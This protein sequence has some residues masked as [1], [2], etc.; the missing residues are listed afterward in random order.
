MASH[1]PVPIHFELP[2]GWE[3]AQPDEVGAPGAA[4]VAL[5]TA[6]R[7][8]GF[9]ANITVDGSFRPNDLAVMADESVRQISAAV[10]S[11]G[12]VSRE[13]AGSPE[14]PCLM[15]DLR[16]TADVNGVVRE[17]AQFQVYLTMGWSP[18]H[19]QSAVVRA[20]LTCAD[21][22][23]ADVLDDFRSFV[24]TLTGDTP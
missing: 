21:D 15:Q 8:A 2:D 3:S 20:T 17:L 1:L 4:F 23:I 14:A 22:Q 13:E 7:G 5:N 16:A 9:T 12:V 19:R 18:D 11:V 10:H 6:T 24:G